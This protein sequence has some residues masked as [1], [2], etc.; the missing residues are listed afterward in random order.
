MLPVHSRGLLERDSQYWACLHAERPPAF[1]CC[2]EERC[3]HC[4]V[5]ARQHA[6]IDPNA[7]KVDGELTD[8]DGNVIAAPYSLVEW[9]LA[10]PPTGFEGVA[11]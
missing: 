2:Y 10:N 1:D 11:L 9:T 5:V 6:I 7:A 3:N 8:Y 4:R